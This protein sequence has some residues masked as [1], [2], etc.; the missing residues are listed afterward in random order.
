[1]L[2]GPLAPIGCVS[3]TAYQKCRECPYTD[4]G[5]CPVQTVMLDVRN[6]IAGILDNYKLADFVKH[7]ERSP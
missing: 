4:K 1:V 2:D 3:K 6:A 7:A 5:H